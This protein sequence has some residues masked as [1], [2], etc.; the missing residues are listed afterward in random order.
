MA[1]REP[2]PRDNPLKPLLGSQNCGRLI[3]ASPS[4]PRLWC[5]SERH[6]TVFRLGPDG[7]RGL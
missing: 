2:K 1:N 4:H 7:G 6:R 3:C 5:S